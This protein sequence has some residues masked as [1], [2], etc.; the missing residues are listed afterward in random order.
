M[1]YD[2][3][4]YVANTLNVNH[5]P[6][7]DGNWDLMAQKGNSGSSGTSGI[8]GVDGINGSSGSSGTSGASG[9]SGSAGSSGTSGSSGSSGSSGTSGDSLFISGAGYYYTTNNLEV[10]GSVRIKGTLTAEQYNVTL[11]SSSVLYS[12]GST[13]FGDTQDDTHVFTGSLTTTGSVVINGDLTVNGTSIMK[14]ID[15]RESLIVSGAMNIVSNQVNASV[16]SASLAFESVK[17]IEQVL[18]STIMDLGYF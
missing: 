14:A 12:S 13:K 11:V 18:N 17:V 8:S 9:S 16:V 1:T 3:S 7:G 6:A 2:G 10:T 4:S 15:N 5:I